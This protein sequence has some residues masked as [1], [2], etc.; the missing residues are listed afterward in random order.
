MS[1]DAVTEITSG[2]DAG[3]VVVTE[4]QSFLSDGQKVPSGGIEPD[5]LV[6]AGVK[7][8]P[9]RSVRRTVAR[10]QLLPP[11][12]D[13][14]MPRASRVDRELVRGMARDRGSAPRRALRRGQ[15]ARR[16]G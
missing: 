6:E 8:R 14:S 2:L 10:H 3:S 11:G 5:D 9:G 16:R 4:G 12:S 15:A 13:R 7:K 1:T